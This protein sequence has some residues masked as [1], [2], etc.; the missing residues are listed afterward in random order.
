MQRKL[1]NLAPLRKQKLMF[2][3][4]R[5]L[6]EF[7]QNRK[8]KLTFT[9]S[10]DASMLNQ[11]S[12]LL[13]DTISADQLTQ[14]STNNLNNNFNNRNL[15][16]GNIM[17]TVTKTLGGNGG[18]GAGILGAGAGV[19]M[20]T[21]GQKKERKEILKKNRE[22]NDADFQANFMLRRRDKGLA[23]METE[24]FIFN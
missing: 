4:E 17:G 3:L 21:M 6:S 15:F 8:T 18:A 23:Q 20:A 14:I 10:I 7:N 13:P 16:L 19:A 1:E 24:V 2:E 5:K 22:L 11:N 9:P 12:D